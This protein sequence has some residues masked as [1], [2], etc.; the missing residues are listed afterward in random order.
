MDKRFF[1]QQALR[2]TVGNND[3]QRA[4]VGHVDTQSSSQEIVINLSNTVIIGP[5]IK[6]QAYR[7]IVLPDPDQNQG[8]CHLKKPPSGGQ[9]IQ[10]D[11]FSSF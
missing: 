11:V 3:N 1:F 4:G 7:S 10:P 9:C 6:K 5:K 2:E 8:R